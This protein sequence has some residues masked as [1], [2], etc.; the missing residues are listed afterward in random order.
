M[1]KTL[2]ETVKKLPGIRKLILERNALQTEIA[3]LQAKLL[4][5]HTEL[6][7]C[8]SGPLLFTNSQSGRNPKG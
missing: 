2:K 4:I 3:D 5:Y 8:S 1:L 7:F 6:S